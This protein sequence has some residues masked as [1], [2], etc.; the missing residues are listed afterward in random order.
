MGGLGGW[1]G[2]FGVGVVIWLNPARL[3]AVLSGLAYYGISDDLQSSAVAF[4]PV[5]FLSLQHLRAPRDVLLTSA[6]L[7]CLHAGL[8][9]SVLDFVMVS[10]LCIFTAV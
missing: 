3:D 4:Q 6:S 1:V 7:A 9:R 10:F 2:W 8:I 5:P